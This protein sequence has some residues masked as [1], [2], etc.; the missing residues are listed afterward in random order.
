LDKFETGP[1]FENA[2]KK[3]N[4]STAN[5]DDEQKI[6]VA[7]KNLEKCNG[8]LLNPDKIRHDEIERC[9]PLLLDG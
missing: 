6:Q 1:L 8:L 2:V 9:V 4:A 3:F 5:L 7:I